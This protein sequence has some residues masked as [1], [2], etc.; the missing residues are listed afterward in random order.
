M[1]IQ[2][3][4]DDSS[5]GHAYLQLYDLD[6]TLPTDKNYRYKVGKSAGIQTRMDYVISNPNNLTGRKIWWWAD[7]YFMAAPNL[8]HLAKITGDPKYAAA[9]DSMYWDSASYLFSPEDNLF[10]RDDKYFPGQPL[11]STAHGNRVV[12]ARAQ[13]WTIA[14][15]A[16]ILTYLPTSDPQYGNFV[17]QFQ[18]LAASAKACQQPSGL[19]HTSLDDSN[20]GYPGAGFPTPGLVDGDESSGSSFLLY[21]LAWGINNGLLSSAT[22]GNVVKNG[23]IALQSKIQPNGSLG[24]SE[25]V[26][27]APAEVQPTDTTD[28]GSGAF[29]L[30]GL[31]VNALYGTH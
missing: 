10:F 13:G 11:G 21:G 8:A 20:D 27:Q 25:I 22:Y 12:W 17:A 9:L 24:Y 19:W 14:A 6:P 29:A 23:W 3:H 28:F 15:L 4:A 31:E 16:E 1:D 7:A 30:A 2:Y 5:A 26:G 18:S